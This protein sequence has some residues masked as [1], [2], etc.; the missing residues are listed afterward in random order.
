MKPL[1]EYDLADLKNKDRN[2]RALELAQKEYDEESI[3]ET[4]ITD[5]DIVRALEED[6]LEKEGMRKEITI[7]NQEE[8]EGV[9]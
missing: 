4:L 5:E 7:I 6:T 3:D 1:D 2:L 9:V 8:L